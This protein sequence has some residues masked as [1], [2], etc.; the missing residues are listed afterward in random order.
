MVV[1]AVVVGDVGRHGGGVA[2]RGARLV[3][4]R[5]VGVVLENFEVL[6]GGRGVQGRVHVGLALGY[7]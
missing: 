6:S 5:G 4:V 1:L 7:G 3:E 2:G